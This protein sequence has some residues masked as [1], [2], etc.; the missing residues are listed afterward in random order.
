MCGVARDIQNVHPLLQK[1]HPYV[2]RTRY[3]T[4][5]NAPR[6]IHHGQMLLQPKLQAL[7]KKKRKKERGKGKNRGE[8]PSQQTT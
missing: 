1:A 6:G 4:S 8:N 5:C 7:P 2:E 3:P